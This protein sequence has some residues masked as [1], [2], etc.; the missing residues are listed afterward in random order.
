MKNA[1]KVKQLT[2]PTSAVYYSSCNNNFNITKVLIGL[3]SASVTDGKDV[4]RILAS[5]SMGSNSCG[6]KFGPAPVSNTLRYLKSGR[7][8]A[9]DI[10]VYFVFPSLHQHNFISKINCNKY[11]KKGDG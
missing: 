1:A 7:Q 2:T 4:V 9:S 10:S 11:R 8:R 6:M 5:N 3:L